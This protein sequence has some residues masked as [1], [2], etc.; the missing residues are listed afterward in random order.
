MHVTASVFINDGKAGLHNYEVWLEILAPREP[1][2]QYR[3][4]DTGKDN[5]DAHIKRRVKGREVV[6]AVTTDEMDS[7]PWEQIF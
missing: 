5:A 7:G 2:Y 4:N 1:V 6:A 3:H